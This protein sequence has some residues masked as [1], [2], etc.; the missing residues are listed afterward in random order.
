MAFLVPQA[1]WLLALLPVVVAL[2]FLRARRRRRDVSALFLWRR[3]Q[4]SVA[5][6][7]RFS[8]SWLLAL[9]LLFVAAVAVGLAGPYLKGAESGALAVV[10]DASAS[11]A[12]RFEGGTRLGAAV[13][14]ARTR[15]RTTGPVALVRAGLAP[16][17]L[18]PL[19]AD[20]QD[21]STALASL[22]AGDASADLLAAVDLGMSLLPG[23][24]VLVYT[25]RQV[26]LGKAQVV[27]VGA[28]E[29]AE[30]DNV[31]ISAFDVGV[32]EAFVALVA[33]GRRPA[34]ATVGLFGGGVELARSTLLVPGGGTAAVTFPLLA[35]VAEGEGVLEARILAP[36]GDALPLDDVAFAGRRAL[37]VVTD[38]LY[39]P[40]LRALNAVPGVAVYGAVDA[41][42]RPAD[43]H[44]LTRHLPDEAAIAALPPGNYL[45]FQPAAQAPA[46]HVVRDFDRAADVMRF[47][48]LRDALIGLDPLRPS[49]ESASDT[50]ML[51]EAEAAGDQGG[52]ETSSASAPWR[53][54][55]RADDLTPLLRTRRT[56]AGAVLQFAFHPSQSDL[57]L[58][59]AFPALLANW[60]GSLDVTPR[61]RLG[62]AL[63]GGEV[64]LEPG[65]YPL[66][67]RVEA[68]AEAGS[69]TA[70]SS[71]PASGGAVALASLLAPDESRLGAAAAFS[72][73]ADA[74]SEQ[75]AVGA[76][77]GASGALDEES[78]VGTSPTP[79]LTG[80]IAVALAALAAEWWLYAG[81][82]N[83]GAR[84]GSRRRLVG[85]RA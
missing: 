52:S 53:V 72:D 20:D 81:S 4:A 40:L 55:A 67:A 73:A 58:R 76:V 83:V 38:D 48:D 50:P 70:S 29:S 78:G 17:L 64:V 10:I 12:A 57:V 33:S 44:V 16:R 56:D 54:L 61:V 15:L 46:Y 82:R 25:D 13:D 45:L 31:G 22:Q 24:E 2:H 42:S 51:P 35:D 43:L 28:T 69:R 36:A 80:L 19:A 49:W 3:A 77:E 5:R 79:L 68:G 26:A 30:P 59:P 71:P 34:E 1:L 37:T 65:V 63:P 62:E 39:A 21:R 11:M 66:G 85:W 32:G 47:V 74:A 7:R 75:G 14:A 41:A 9:Q 84:A 18:A 8:P 23:A 27:V 6:R 60:V